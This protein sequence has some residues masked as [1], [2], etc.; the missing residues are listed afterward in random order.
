MA[1]AHRASSETIQDVTASTYDNPN[2]SNTQSYTTTTGD[3]ALLVFFF[4]QSTGP[5]NVVWN[6]SGGTA[7]T[8]IAG[9]DDED[10]SGTFLY[11]IE[12]PD[13]GTH[14]LWFDTIGNYTYTIVIV[15]ITSMDTAT[16]PGN[17][18]SDFGYVASITMNPTTVADDFL[19]GGCSS[20]NAATLD[21]G[22]SL[23]TDQA[24]SSGRCSVAYATASGAGQ[25]L[26]WSHTTHRMSAAAV[27]LK[28]SS[29]GGI[30]VPTVVHQLKSQ[31]IS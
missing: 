1:V 11:Y 5:A 31:G 10:Q 8:L 15:A 21:T 18:D 16:S 19:I 30:S 24:A 20:V 6:G 9:T 25:T 23:Y 17:N 14:D 29:G 3:N 4:G 2:W 7:M 27:I 26:V 28:P 12:N 22:T 13:I